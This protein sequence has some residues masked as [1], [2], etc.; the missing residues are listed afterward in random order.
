MTEY[1]FEV[2]AKYSDV[3]TVEA[4]TYE[5]A[6]VLALESAPGWIDLGGKMAYVED[7][8]AY[9]LDDK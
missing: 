4:D 6:Y 9:N 5:R 3:I 2:V 7:V 1:R 8:Q